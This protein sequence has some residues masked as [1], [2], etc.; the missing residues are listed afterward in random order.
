MLMSPLRFFSTGTGA[1]KRQS[2]IPPIA[3]AKFPV[4]A[5]RFTLPHYPFQPLPPPNGP[6]PYR[7]DLS[8]LL[9]P[10][11]I[12]KIKNGTLVFQTVGDTGDFRGRQQDFVSAMMTLDSQA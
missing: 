10:D 11:D 12:T 4:Q 5:A 1:G 8:Q 6:A 3:G 2:H 7:F 9:P